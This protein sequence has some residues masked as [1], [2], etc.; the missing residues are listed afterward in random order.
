MPIFINRFA[1][2]VSTIFLFP[3]FSQAQQLKKF[4]SLT[5]EKTGINF[6][7]KLVENAANNIITYEYFYNGGGV[8]AGDFNN[9]GLVDLYFTSN[10]GGNKLYLN[11][12]NWQFKDITAAAGVEGR[13]GWK[14]GVSVA[15][16]N[17]DGLLDIY[18]CYSGDVAPQKRAN[19]LFINNGNL[20]FTDKAKEMGVA[21]DGYSTHAAFFDYDKDG[22][23]DLFVVNHNIKN[24]R[25]FDASFVKKMVDPDAGDRLYENRKG[26][27]VNVTERAGIISNP[28][29]YGL[30]LNIADVNNDGWPDIYVSNDYIE[31]DYL[32]INNQDGTYSEQ[33]RKGIGHLSYFSMGLDIADINNDGFQDIFTLDMLPQDNRRQKLLY[34]PD[35]YEMYNN[36]LGNGFYHQLMRN[37]LQLNNGNGSFSEIGQLAG[38]SNTDWSWSA[39][40]ADYNNDGKKDL[41]VTNGYGRDMINRDFV[42]F[43]ANERLKHV[44]GKKN[45]RMFLMLQG[46]QSTPT[47]NFIY[48]GGSQLN[49]ID[50]TSEW[51]FEENNF[52]HGAIYADLDN[53][54]DLDLVVNKMNQAAGIYRNNT[55]ETNKGGNFLAI[56]LKANSNN[57]NAIGAK[58]TAYCKSGKYFF[59]NNPIHGFQSSMQVPVHIGF[60][61]AVIDSLVITWPDMTETRITSGITSN[62]RIEIAQ[63]RFA[64]KLNMA[65]INQRPIF[66]VI[67]N[68]IPFVHKDDSVNDFK[69]QPLLP[70]M[71][72]YAGPKVAYADLNKDGLK[73]VYICGTQQQAGG[74]FLQ[75]ANKGFVKSN[76]PELNV[77][78]E[79]A[80]T[81]AVFF[82][83]DLDGDDDLYIVAGGFALANSGVAFQ[84]KLILNNKGHFELSKELISTTENGGS[85]VVPL[86]FDEDGDLDLFIGA[87]AVSGKYP[88]PAKSRLLVNNGK[89]KFTDET[90]SVAPAFLTLGLVT[91]A[92]W[93]KNKE[94]QKNSLIISGEWMSL[95]SFNFKNG[96]FTNTSN[97]IFN[98]KLSGWWNKLAFNDVDNDGDLDLVAG[99]WGTNSQIKADEKEQVKLYYS[100]FDNNGS[101][102]PIITY[103]VNG[104]SYPMASRDE[105]TDQITSMRQKFP[106]YDAYADATIN[107][108]L[109]PEQIK[110]GGVLTANFLNT[111]WFENKNGVYFKRSLPVQADFSPVYAITIDDYNKDGFK[112]ILLLGNTEKARIKIGKI[113]ANYGT[114]LIGNGKGDFKYTSQA[115]SGLNIKGAVRDALQVSS[116]TLLITI[117]N[118]SPLLL[119]Y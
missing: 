100:D 116:S 15:D 113:D 111:T 27:F 112:D 25:N 41:F 32:Y 104:I 38:V 47:H 71:I 105:I 106:T 72:S 109:T 29:G 75:T 28:I 82:D 98:E 55:V 46:I 81:A 8:G 58:L 87:R 43:Y 40:L 92:A 94:G 30:G 83:A 51:G 114:L 60:P 42:K 20:T 62:K 79:L 56:T 115:S 86:D 45:D 37:M 102:D 14:T 73:D 77:I 36:M 117:N 59:E 7:N 44:Q 11:K 84:D 67:E 70:S 52:S 19:Q 74:L 108:V 107:E 12:G 119:K 18:V 54:G 17:G 26:I 61:D 96:V 89:G 50:R 10:Q 91:D 3:L 34:A 99:N 95:M 33:L 110:A 85:C 1:F 39:L 5:A 49:F 4:T 24:L 9:D 63:P 13:Q 90:A 103:Y 48:E 118:Q 68:A 80:E 78:T 53:D 22:D 65:E 64:P 6:N 23:L 16:V 66:S 97:T 76:Q 2:F 93:V 101:I 88:V 57:V 69:V 35:N 21:D 31:E